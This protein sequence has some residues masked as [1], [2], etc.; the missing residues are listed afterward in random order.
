M[1]KMPVLNSMQLSRDTKY[2]KNYT[3]NYTNSAGDEKIYETVSNFHYDSPAQIGEKAS[4]VVIVGFRRDELLLTKEFRMGVNHLIYGL[5]AGHIDK[6]ETPEECA[7]RELYEETGLQ[8]KKIHDVLPPA[9]AAPDL[10]DASAWLVIADV[11][12]Q[13]SDHTEDNE[14]IVPVF[15][16]KKE[17][18][19]LIK[20]ARFSAR[21]QIIDYSFIN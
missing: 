11:D 21:A 7:R 13:F 9:Y 16:T 19:S 12:G 3:L 2:L 6:G 10:T 17:L 18:R 14:W 4:G 15:L 20:T 1:K 8:I 5:P